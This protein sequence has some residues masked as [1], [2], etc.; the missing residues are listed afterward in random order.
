MAILPSPT[1]LSVAKLTGK[2]M[3]SASPSWYPA[4]VLQS[5]LPQ[6]G[7]K[8]HPFALTQGNPSGS[9]VVRH[10]P[11]APTQGHPNGTLDQQRDI[12]AGKQLGEARLRG[13]QIF[14]KTPLGKTITLDV[15][16]FGG[17]F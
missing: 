5:Q 8:R 10:L 7:H 4:V 13:Q 3:G 17:G 2:T 11:V 16:A 12:F 6:P 15:E 9:G 14:V 1:R